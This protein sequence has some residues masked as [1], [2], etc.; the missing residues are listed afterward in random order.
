M[1]VC[2]AMGLVAQQPALLLMQDDQMHVSGRGPRSY[3]PSWVIHSVKKASHAGVKRPGRRSCEHGITVAVFFS[4]PHRC[5]YTRMGQVLLLRVN[6]RGG[7]RAACDIAALS[8]SPSPL[9]Q[10]PTP[11]SKFR[12][13]SFHL[14]LWETNMCF[15]GL[16]LWEFHYSVS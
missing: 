11:S 6:P 12:T 3:L 15:G 4:N 2:H 5:C 13:N 7:T 14:Q 9:G 10:S 8:R 1:C 16:P